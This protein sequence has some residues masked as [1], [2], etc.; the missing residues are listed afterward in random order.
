[1]GIASTRTGRGYW[2]VASDGGVFNFGDAFFRGSAGNL[3]LN[4]PVVGVAANG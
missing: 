1:V 4:A 3:A 2:M